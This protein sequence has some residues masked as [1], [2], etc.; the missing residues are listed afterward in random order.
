[1][2]PL[3]STTQYNPI[4]FAP[5]FSINIK[6]QLSGDILFPSTK[7]MDCIIRESAAHDDYAFVELKHCNRFIEC[8]RNFNIFK[9][10][11]INY[12]VCISYI[13]SEEK[14]SLE[15]RKFR[16]VLCFRLRLIIY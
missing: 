8:S 1:M 5:N 4:D 16:S 7:L 12:L 2:P 15:W 13:N 14:Y 9:M 6:F 3:V 11:H 10:Y